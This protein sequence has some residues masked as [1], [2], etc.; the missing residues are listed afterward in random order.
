LKAVL[1][2]SPIIAF[3][4][5]LRRPDVLLLTRR[6]GY[7][8]FVPHAVVEKDIVK[9]PGA[10]GLQNCLADSSISRLP[11]IDR[12]VLAKFLRAHPSLGDG[13]SETII[14]VKVFCETGERALCVLDEGPA[15]RIARSLGLEM[16]GTIG[17]INELGRLGILDETGVE[18][19]KRNLRATTFR[20]A[21]RFLK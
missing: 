13:E 19:L 16:K 21:E 7:E 14:H 10:T 9:E 5:E 6:I 4:D 11:P 2:A 3:F 8:L 18:S 20:V 17:I 12:E 1:D 15:R